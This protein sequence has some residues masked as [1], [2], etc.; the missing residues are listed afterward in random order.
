MQSK[1]HLFAVARQR[2][3]ASV[4][5]LELPEGATVSHLKSALA[6]AYPDLAP[7]VPSLMIAIDNDYA[8]DDAPIPPGAELAAIPPVSGG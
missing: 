2:A 6:A 5:T 8:T 7:I 3:G 1:I 4:V